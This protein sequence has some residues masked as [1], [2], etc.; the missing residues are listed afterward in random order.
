MLLFPK[1][2]YKGPENVTYF[3]GEEF[4]KELAR[5]K[6]VK[7]LIEFYATWNPDCNEFASVFGELSAKYASKNLKFGKIDIAR[8][9]KI[10]DKYDVV[11]SVTSRT[12]PTLI[13]FKDGRENI[14]RPLIDNRDRIVPFSFSYV[15]ITSLCILVQD[16]T[17]NSSAC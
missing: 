12:L 13:L 14:R 15:S 17:L 10:A 16:N 6:K 2:K 4:E 1:P 5:D 8:S 11:A 3:M 9:P 7:W